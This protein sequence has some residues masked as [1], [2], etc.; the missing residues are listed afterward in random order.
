MLA[1]S[2]RNWRGEWSA[3]EA[4]V[5]KVRYLKNEDLLAFGRSMLQGHNGPLT[6]KNLARTLLVKRPAFRHERE[7][8][9][10]FTPHDFH[11][12]TDRIVSYPV[13]P[14]AFV[15]QM[16][17]DPRIDKEDAA[18]LMKQIAEAGFRGPIRRSLLYAPPPDLMIPWEPNS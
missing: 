9:L 14:N 15:D 17:L 10:L 13:E 3:Q 2:L 1:E 8:R 5:G 18:T 4:Y 12:F 11:N 16:M 7:I 6:H